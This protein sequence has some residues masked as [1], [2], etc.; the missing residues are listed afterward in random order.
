LLQVEMEQL[1]MRYER[2]RTQLETALD[3][4]VAR[5]SDG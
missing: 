5:M 2:A 3:A 4:L 1:Q